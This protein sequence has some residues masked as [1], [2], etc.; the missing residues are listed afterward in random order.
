MVCVT[1]GEGGPKC[2]V[3]LLPKNPR[4]ESTPTYRLAFGHGWM[5]NATEKKRGVHGK[6]NENG[7]AKEMG[8]K[9][10]SQRNGKKK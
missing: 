4:P 3:V 6:I 8:P 10:W 1:K 2:L 7:P 9:K 5:G